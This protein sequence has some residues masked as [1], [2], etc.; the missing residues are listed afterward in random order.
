MKHMFVMSYWNDTRDLS[1]KSMENTSTIFL[2][3]NASDNIF[4]DVCL[5]INLSLL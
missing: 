3:D 4:F 1:L 5:S 2:P